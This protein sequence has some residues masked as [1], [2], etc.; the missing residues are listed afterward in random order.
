MSKI[1]TMSKTEEQLT[2]ELSESHRRITQPMASE[3]K[4]KQ[5]GEMQKESEE[6][7]KTKQ[8]KELK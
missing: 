1:D 5:L 6:K 3:T 2:K 8:K 7:E 4:R